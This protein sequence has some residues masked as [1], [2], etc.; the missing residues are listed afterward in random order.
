MLLFSLDRQILRL[1]N[2]VDSARPGT[3]DSR[4]VGHL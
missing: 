1:K 2:I 4:A 3:F